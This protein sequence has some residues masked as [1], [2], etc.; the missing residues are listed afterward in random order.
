MELRRDDQ[1]PVTP[2]P[3]PRPVVPD[4][5]GF[6][7]RLRQAFSDFD[8]ATLCGLHVAPMTVLDEAGSTW[9]ADADAVRAW[10][11]AR[12]AGYRAAGIGEVRAETLAHRILGGAHAEANV[13]WSLRRRDGS[14]FCRF[15]AT[16]LIRLDGKPRIAFAAIHDERRNWPDGE[17]I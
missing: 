16:Y 4:L 14:R 12:V 8:V 3:A 9:L 7:V 6:L 2:Q 17:T 10:W 15:H 13:T 5:A 1:T 11:E